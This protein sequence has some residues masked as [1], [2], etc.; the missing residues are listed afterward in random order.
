MFR[1]FGRTDLEMESFL[2]DLERVALDDLYPDP[3]NPRLGLDD[4]PGYE[5]PTALFDEEVRKRISD[6]LGQDAYDVDGL[7][8]AVIGQGWMPIDNIIVWQHPSVPGRRVVVEGNRRWL[9]LERIRT[10]EL[11]KA[12][13]KLARMHAKASAYPKTDI[14]EQA[15]LVAHL[16]QIIVDTAALEV[17]PI[18]ATTVE[19]L[20]HKLPRVLAVRHITGAKT[21]GNFAEDLW[22]LNRFNQLFEDTH[23]ADAQLFWDPSVIGRVADEASLGHTVAKRKLKSAKWYSHFRAE[24]E[25]E[26]PDGEEF[27]P[28]DYYLF[29]NISRKPWV[30]QQFNIGEDD[31][32]ISPESEQTLF[33]WVFRLP[34]GKTAADNP[35]VFYRHENVLV[36][37]Q[38]KRYD[39]EHGSD[40]AGRFQVDNPDDAPTMSEVEAEWRMHKVRRKP[41]AVL[42]ELLRRLAELSAET[43]T[44]EGRVLR[45]QLQKLGELAD[46]Y[47]KMIDAAEA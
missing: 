1:Y 16:E 27:E 15:A 41:H 36:W 25:D 33:T 39:D 26:L 3:N 2:R 43:L 45:V 4:A 5:D 20:E 11:G 38:M 6:D 31:M 46:K 14:N 10:V 44:S 34:R 42:D 13:K 35:N 22:L 32:V 9:T 24:W 30:R 7:V 19:E 12:Q 28:S 23:G 17:V 29:E 21:W 47:V 8:E 40:F 18:N 37:D